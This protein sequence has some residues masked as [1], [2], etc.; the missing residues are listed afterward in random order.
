LQ[1]RISIA[2]APPAPTVLYV[3]PDAIASSE[4]LPEPDRDDVLLRF[5]PGSEYLKTKDSPTVRGHPGSG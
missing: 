2:V 1:V 3:R 5:S 4:H